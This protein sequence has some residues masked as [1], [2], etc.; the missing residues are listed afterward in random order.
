MLWK[1]GYNNH[2]NNSP[3]IGYSNK[4]NNYYSYVIPLKNTEPE[5][6]ITALS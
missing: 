3:G 5:L 4:V 6:P 1:G 2:R